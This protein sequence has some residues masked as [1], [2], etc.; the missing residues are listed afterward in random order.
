MNFAILQ[1]ELN[2]CIAGVNRY[3]P[4]NVETL[5]KC[6]QAMVLENQYD[7]NILMT[8]LKLYQLNPD[9]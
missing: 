2:S 9:K 7:M 5:E 4:N 8:L 3:N 6:V 1:E